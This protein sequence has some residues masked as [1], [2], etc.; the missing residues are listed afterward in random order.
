MYARSPSPLH[1][2]CLSG[3]DAV[4]SG[5]PYVQH[6]G[7][8]ALYEVEPTVKTYIGM[9]TVFYT[10]FKVSIQVQRRDDKTDI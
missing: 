6:G 1:F 5:N 10:V 7:Y 3:A 8:P 9:K 4:E 2:F